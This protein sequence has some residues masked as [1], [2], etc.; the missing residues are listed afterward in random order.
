[1]TYPR[2]G[3]HPSSAHGQSA[4][5]CGGMGAVA[6]K[7]VGSRGGQVG[8]SAPMEGEESTAFSSSQVFSPSSGPASL[9]GSGLGSPGPSQQR[10]SSSGFE[11]G[12]P[13]VLWSTVCS[14]Q[15]HRRVETGP[16]PVDPELFS[17]YEAF[18]HGDRL[19]GQGC[20]S[21]RG[22]GSIDRSTGRLLPPVNP[23]GG[24]EVSPLFVE[25]GGIPVP[26]GAFWPGP[27]SMALHQNNK[28]V[29]RS[30][31]GSRY[32]SESLH[33]RLAAAGQ[34]GDF[35]SSTSQSSTGSL[36]VSG[37]CSERGEDRFGPLPAVPLLGYGVQYSG[38]DGS[39][40]PS[41]N[42]SSTGLAVPGKSFGIGDSSLSSIHF[43]FDGIDVAP[44]TSW[45]SPQAQGPTFVCGEMDSG[46]EQLVPSY[47]SGRGIS[48]SYLSVAESGLALQGGPYYASPSSGILVHRRIPRGMGCALGQSDSSGSVGR[49]PLG[50]SHQPSG[51]GGSM[52]SSQ[53]VCRFSEG[54]TCVGEH[55]QHDSSLLHQ[56]TRGG[57]FIHSISTSR[58]NAALVRG[59]SDS[60]DGQIP[61]RKIECFSGRPQPLSLDPSDGVDASPRGSASNLEALG[62]PSCGSLCDSLQ[63][64]SP[65][66]CVSSFGSGGLGG[67][68]PLSSLGESSGV[69][70]PTVSHSGESDSQSARRRRYPDSYSPALGSPALV[71]GPSKS[72]SSG[73]DPSEVKRKSSNPTK[74]RHSARKSGSSKS[75]RLVSV[76]QSLSLR[77]ASR[78]VIDLVEHA[79]RPGTKKL[80]RARWGAW[81]SW[82]ERNDVSPASPSQVELANYLA[83]LSLKKKLSAST[84]KGHRASICTTLRQMGRSSF[85]E[86]PLLKDLVKGMLLKEARTPRRF[87]AWDIFLVLKSLRLSPYEP[88][89][90]CELKFLSFKTAFL[91]SLAS[92]RRCSEIHA[93]AFNGLAT[94]TDGSISIRFLPEFLAKNQPVNFHSKPIVV[95]ALAQHLCPDDEDIKLCPVRS[96][97]AYLRRTKFLRSPAKRRLFVSFREDK[98]SDLTITSISR[99]IKT[100]IR[101]AYSACSPENVP[102]SPGSTR[103]HEVRAWASS[104]AWAHNTS[105]Q[106]I[107]EAGFWFCQATFLQYYLRDVAH[108][109]EDGSKGISF[110]AAQCP[111]VKT[112]SSSGKSSTKRR[113]SSKSSL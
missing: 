106:A 90:S 12:V 58:G 50:L 89:D 103:A 68:C 82:C 107:M 62:P 72:G 32:S 37:L 81:V 30:G 47:S 98:R 8:V 95:R 48:S 113:S 41:E 35:L 99:W 65:S 5:T 25:G 45:S 77:G 14:P 43:G 101:Q 1:M 84:V 71:P 42:C 69:C 100:V 110:V 46:V 104:L 21:A 44:T 20:Y 96:L 59:S 40:V 83:F 73:S 67:R 74:I 94:E 60:S 64:A 39:A 109:R 53:A 51:V 76:R 112:G 108:E 85:S 36:H 87:P 93:L 16:R 7:R 4:Q 61:P 29:M 13:G 111:V 3:R 26:G 23:R 24:S 34:V 28:R 18:S 11:Q 55:R 17:Q 75:A 31:E 54:Q 6:R 102:A 52:V 88:V 33:R 10:G 97:K 86:D 57:S 80:Y 78:D 2:P 63:Q 91:V 27:S 56:Q 9:P 22:L 92:G 15:I 70:I 66:V 19:I 49:F 38:V 79:H 105:L